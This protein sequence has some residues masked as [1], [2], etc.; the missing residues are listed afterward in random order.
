MFSIVGATRRS[1][2]L[3]ARARRPPGHAS[4]DL[5]QFFLFLHDF[6]KKNLEKGIKNIAK[7]KHF[8][9]GRPVAA[10]QPSPHVKDSGVVPVR[11]SNQCAIGTYV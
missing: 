2:F 4:T 3:P 10:T 5:A 7:L 11:D 8:C 1:E 9:S 6:L